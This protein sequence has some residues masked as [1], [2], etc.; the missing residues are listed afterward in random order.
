[1]KKIVVI[2]GTGHFGGRI[3]RRIAG[4]N[5]TELVVTSRSRARAQIIV[6]ELRASNSAA[7]S[8]AGLDQSL[9][10]FE[11]NLLALRPDIVIH[12]AGPY[13]GQDYRVAKAC[14]QA[15]S[16]YIDLADGRDFVQGFDSLHNEA[17]RNDLLLVSGASTLPGLSSAVID[18]LRGDFEIIRKIEI[19]IAPAHQTP[20]GKSTIAAVL[21]Y[22]GTSFQVLVDGN[23]VTKHGWQ[24]LTRHRYPGFGVRL[25]GACDVPDLGILPHYVDGVDT[26]TFHAALEAKWEQLALWSMGWVTRAGIVRKWDGFVP[27]FQ[28]I[29]DRLIGLGSDVGGMRITMSGTSIDRKPK[30][31]TWNLIARQNHGPEI[32]CSPAL[33]LARKLAADR[34][35]VRGALPCLGMFSMSDFENELSDFDVRWS[36][37]ES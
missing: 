28:K 7:I 8:A 29:S 1:L 4:E 20:R 27:M 32:P 11:T 31:I 2:G 22:C 34:I 33:I 30:S 17:K 9:Q 16:H 21:S 12:T 13:Q 18:S 19:S 5:N 25:G 15:G 6:D 36:T 3:C 23:W 26:V 10:D 24:D 35:A 37:I 14:I